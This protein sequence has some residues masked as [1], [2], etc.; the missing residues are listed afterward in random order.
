MTRG[1]MYPLTAMLGEEKKKYPGGKTLAIIRSGFHHYETRDS[2]EDPVRVRVVNA[3]PE[4]YIVG[5][6]TLASGLKS[7]NLSFNVRAFGK[8]LVER[9]RGYDSWDIE[10]L[11]F[12]GHVTVPGQA[13]I[14]AVGACVPY[15]RATGYLHFP[16]ST[17][18]D[19][20]FVP[21]PQEN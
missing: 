16:D 10:A 4:E 15:E 13:E 3:E 18:L 9:K 19:E 21:R 1:R 6:S 17:Q 7:A 8:A 14:F 20:L 12:A 11:R 2:Y 5:L